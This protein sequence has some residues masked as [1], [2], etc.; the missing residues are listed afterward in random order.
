ML[1]CL[2][3]TKYALVEDAPE[4]WPWVICKEYGLESGSGFTTG[5]ASPF[6]DAEWVGRS[7]ITPLCLSFP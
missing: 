2:P 3:I 4:S 5:G 1:V 7:S 6:L